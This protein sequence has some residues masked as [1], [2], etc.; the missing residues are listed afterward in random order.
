MQH[1]DFDGG[2]TFTTVNRSSN[3]FE[4]DGVTFD[5]TGKAEGLEEENITFKQI[6]MLIV[7]LTKKK[8]FVKEYNN[9]IDQIQGKV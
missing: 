6:I 5:V 7:L 8:E 2:N 9:I 1:C 3:S 4:I